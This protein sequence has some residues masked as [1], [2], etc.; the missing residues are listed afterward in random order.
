MAFL[1]VRVC[2]VSMLMATTLAVRQRVDREAHREADAVHKTV[3]AHQQ[4]GH[5]AH[6]TA[7]AGDAAKPAV[8]SST[9]DG[10]AFAAT[11]TT[12][13]PTMKPCPE[14]DD[15]EDCKKALEISAELTR[16]AMDFSNPLK[17][18]EAQKMQKDAAAHTVKCSECM[19]EKCG[20]GG[21]GKS[22][23][24]GARLSGVAI[25]GILV[26]LAA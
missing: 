21:G 20:G 22:G 2:I 24:P 13:L 7:E 14:C 5:A 18:E 26:W 12:P 1:S 3:E 15:N 16:R 8:A 4:E 17:P 23:A 10:D 11:E 6:K 25:A 9:G 19:V